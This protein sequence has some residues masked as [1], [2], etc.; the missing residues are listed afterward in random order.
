MRCWRLFAPP[1]RFTCSRRIRADCDRRDRVFLNARFRDCAYNAM[2][3][4]KCKKKRQGKTLLVCKLQCIIAKK[5]TSETHY[6]Q[7][8]DRPDIRIQLELCLRCHPFLAVRWLSKVI[9]FSGS[10]CCSGYERSLC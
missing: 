3:P 8:R 9:Y 7:G 10:Y 2:L 1:I 4:D 5:L 6:T